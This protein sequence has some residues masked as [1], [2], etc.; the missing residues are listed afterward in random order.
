LKAR[1]KEP[2]FH[3]LGIFFVF[4]HFL[5]SFKF[6]SLHLFNQS[7]FDNEKVTTFQKTLNI[8]PPTSFMWVSKKC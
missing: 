4:W 2:Y 7:T 1:D 8:T 3:F 6:N 5:R